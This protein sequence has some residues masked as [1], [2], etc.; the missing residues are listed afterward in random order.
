M[1]HVASSK[2]HQT[3]H[4]RCGGYLNM[5]QPL[6]FFKKITSFC[7][8]VKGF[9]N[10]WQ[11][12]S[13][14]LDIPGLRSTGQIWTIST[15]PNYKCPFYHCIHWV[16]NSLKLNFTDYILQTMLCTDLCLKSRIVD[17]LKILN[18][19]LKILNNILS[20][21]FNCSLCI[22]IYPSSKGQGCFGSSLMTQLFDSFSC[23]S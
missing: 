4:Q 8:G 15:S 20:L 21:D 18:L 19:H 13:C 12:T 23:W 11:L 10:H 22:I 9:M 16:W 6:H 14:G 3:H 5:P 2:S 1:E 7:S 17:K